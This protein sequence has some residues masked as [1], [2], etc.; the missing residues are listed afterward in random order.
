MVS[1]EKE[2][3]QRIINL[4]NEMTETYNSLSKETKERIQNESELLNP[5]FSI[6]TNSNSV[7]ENNKLTRDN[8]DFFAGW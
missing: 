1:T 8:K 2:K 4:Y 3:M 5:V 7:A 6:L